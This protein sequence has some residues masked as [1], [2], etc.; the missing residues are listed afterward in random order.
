[1]SGIYTF[2]GGL[3][4]TAAVWAFKADWNVSGGAF[5]LN[6]LTFW[7]FGHVNFL[8]LDVFSIWIPPQYVPFALVTWTITNVTS[9]IVPFSVSNG[10]YRWGYALPAHAAY[11]ILTDIWSG[12]CNPHLYFALP[13][14]FSYEV[15]GFFGTS[16]GV[17]KRC[18]LAVVAEEA[19]KEASLLLAETKERRQSRARTLSSADGGRLIAEG[20]RRTAETMLADTEDSDQEQRERADEEDERAVEE[21]QRLETRAT[22]I[23]SNFGPS[24]QLVGSE[25]S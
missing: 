11:E 20:S 4:I 2:L 3:L 16:L 15:L 14:L 7:L 13:I 5:V 12:G 19:N 21:I 25:G 22:R 1:V 9:V 23:L 24:F 6:W 18:H 8:V 10:F 17:Y